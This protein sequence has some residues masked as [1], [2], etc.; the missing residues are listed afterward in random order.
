VMFG[1]FVQ[2][3]FFNDMTDIDLKKM[4]F[5]ERMKAIEDDIVPFGFIDDGTDFNK[6]LD[7]K[8]DWFIEFDEN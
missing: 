4:L 6:E 1:Y 8:P 5:E 7:Q 2:T 3:Q